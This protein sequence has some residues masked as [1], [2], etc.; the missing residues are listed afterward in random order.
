MLYD[1]V[2]YK[3]TVRL[4]RYNM[5]LYEITL[6][7]HCNSRKVVT[8]LHSF[9]AIQECINNTA[10]IVIAVSSLS[11]QYFKGWICKIYCVNC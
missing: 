8:I 11:D 1:T 7:Q 2:L 6:S 9:F 5:S 10:N 3:G 4:H